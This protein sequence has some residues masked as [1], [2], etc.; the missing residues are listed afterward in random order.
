MAVSFG[1]RKLAADFL[2]NIGVAWFAAGVIGLFVGGSKNLTD[3]F[4]SLGWGIGFSVIFFLVGFRML[5]GVQ[6]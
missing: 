3:L 5:K 2:T 6:L 4:I 1:Q